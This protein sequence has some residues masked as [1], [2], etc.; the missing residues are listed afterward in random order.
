MTTSLGYQTPFP[1]SLYGEPALKKNGLGTNRNSLGFGVVAH[2][3]RLHAAIELLIY[4][5]LL[6]LL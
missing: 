6:H 1:K 4:L 3:D 5:R 2:H